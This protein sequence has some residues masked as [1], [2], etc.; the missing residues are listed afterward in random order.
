MHERPIF[1]KAKSI[2][3]QINSLNVGDASI[4]EIKKH[5]ELLNKRIV[6]KTTP[7]PPDAFFYR[8]RICSSEVKP[9][10]ESEICCPPWGSKSY[11]RVNRPGVSVFYSTSNKEIIHSELKYNIG[12]FVAISAWKTKKLIIVNNVGFSKALVSHISVYWRILVYMHFFEK[13]YKKSV[14][15]LVLSSKHL[16]F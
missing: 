8:G 9:C 15:R 11:Q 12:D 13:G 4:E 1:E 14:L 6:I 5:L 2:I 3:D 16:C 7:I 10:H